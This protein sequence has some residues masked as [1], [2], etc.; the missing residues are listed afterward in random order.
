MMPEQVDHIS[1]SRYIQKMHSST[2][3]MRWQVKN[4]SFSR[5]KNRIISSDATNASGGREIYALVQV[6][7]GQD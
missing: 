6:Y 3:V 2:V 5:Y 4:I 7:N 1:F